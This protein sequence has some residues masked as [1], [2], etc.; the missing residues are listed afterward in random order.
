MNPIGIPGNMHRIIITFIVLIAAGFPLVNSWK[1]GAQEVVP[2]ENNLPIATPQAKEQDPS[3]IFKNKTN[4][5]LDGKF[6][7]GMYNNVLID[8]NLTQNFDKFSYQLGTDFRRSNDFGY[9]NTSFYESQ[10]GLTGKADILEVWKMTPDIQVTNQSYGMHVNPLFSR[11]E[12]D[13]FFVEIKNEFK[14]NPYRFDFNLGGGNHVHRL[15]KINSPRVTKSSFYKANGEFGWETI[16]SASNTFRLNNKAAHYF[17]E[18]SHTT[19]DTDFHNEFVLSF[20]VT[21]YFVF[22]FGAGLN[23]NRDR[24]EWYGMLPF[25]M[26]NISTAGVKYTSIELSYSYDLVPFRPENFY[27]EQ[28]FIMPSYNLPP[29]ETHKVELKA[30][31]DFKFNSDKSFYVKQFKIKGSGTFEY[32]KSFYNYYS[33][34][35][36]NLLSAETIPV[37]IGRARAETGLVFNILKGDR[38]EI[39][40]NYEYCYFYADTYITYRPNNSFGTYIKFSIQRWSLEWE[41][42]WLGPVHVAPE[43]SRTL[44][45]IWLGTLNLQLQVLDSFYLYTILENM[46]NRKIVFRE[47]YPEPGIVFS[48]GIRI[49]I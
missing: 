37:M 17:Y 21:E 4:V 20:K 44:R 5:D 11:E 2:R 33:L 28:T 42:K 31:L 25:G 9:R 8:F 36:E 22:D 46:Y 24:R 18:N 32:N 10:V 16:W 38:L 15:K 30:G 41:N 34:V 49:I 40:A 13:K 23:W 7:Y 3:K 39:G 19:D 26:L 47:G 12:K 45:P 27:F 1:L 35:P 6:L 14:K 48:G 43:S 29:G